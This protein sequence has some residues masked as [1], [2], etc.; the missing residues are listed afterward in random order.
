MAGLGGLVGVGVGRVVVV[1]I[2][3]RV[4]L[5]VMALVM[6]LVPGA[7]LIVCDAREVLGE[8]FN[9]YSPDGL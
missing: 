8:G 2:G 6:E 7:F 4:I 3:R 1:G 5:A 9:E